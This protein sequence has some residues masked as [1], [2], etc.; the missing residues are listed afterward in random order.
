MTREEYLQKAIEK[1]CRP[2]FKNCG[3][4]IPPVKVSTGF[5]GGRG[6]K[7]AIGSHWHPNASDDKIGSIFISPVIDDSLKVIATLM[8]ECVHASVGNEAKHG[9]KFRE[10]AE[11]IG[12]EGK[13]TATYAGSKLE[14]QIEKYVKAHGPYPHAKLNLEMNPTKKQSTRMIKMECTQCGFICR[15]SLT[16][17]LEV[18]PPLCSCNKKPLFVEL[19]EADG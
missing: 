11:L 17:I 1:F 10:C 4:T 14:S 12:L 16:K 6:G 19:P 13:M 8:H 5:P 7:K 15:A 3:Y 9:E 18:G 2:L